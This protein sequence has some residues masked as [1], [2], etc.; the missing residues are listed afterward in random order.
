MRKRT[1]L[2]VAVA[3]LL[4]APICAQES[5]RAIIERCWVETRNGD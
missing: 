5:A 3:F 2:V 1:L 4:A